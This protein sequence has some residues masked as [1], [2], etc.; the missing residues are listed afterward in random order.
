MS[1]THAYFQTYWISAALVDKMEIEIFFAYAHVRLWVCF[2]HVH[3][4]Y[5]CIQDFEPDAE[6]PALGWVG[7][8]L[9]SSFLMDF[10]YQS[11]KFVS[12]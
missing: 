1:L 2:T 4:Q 9:L 7:L 5:W 11:S 6:L 3:A 10:L 8:P 12:N